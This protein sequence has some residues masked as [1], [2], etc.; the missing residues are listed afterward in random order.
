MSSDNEN[1][2]Y[3]IIIYPCGNR[4]KLDLAQICYGMEY[5]ESDYA[6]ASRRKF[7]NEKDAAE[8]CKELA[9]ENGLHFG[10]DLLD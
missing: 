5:E 8:Y 3:Y 10:Y 6:I 2:W 7:D 4:S 9:I 1:S